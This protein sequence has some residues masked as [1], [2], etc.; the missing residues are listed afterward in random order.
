VDGH[1]KASPKRRI[2][3]TGHGVGY[4]EVVVL[5]G[6][7]GNEGAGRWYRAV[8]VRCFGESE[9]GCGRMVGDRQLF[10]VSEEGFLTL[11][12]SLAVVYETLC[13]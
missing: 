9:N 13:C 6:R 3:N 12:E 11:V 10:D 1:R 7:R 4:V 8:S 5:L 2:S